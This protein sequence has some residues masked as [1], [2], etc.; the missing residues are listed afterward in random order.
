MAQYKCLNC[1]EWMSERYLPADGHYH[2]DCGE[3]AEM[4]PVDEAGPRPFVDARR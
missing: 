1:D 3:W 4:V 2:T